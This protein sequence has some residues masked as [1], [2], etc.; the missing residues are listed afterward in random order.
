MPEIDDIPKDLRI[1]VRR[2]KIRLEA[3]MRQVELDHRLIFASG[4]MTAEKFFHLF[5]QPALAQLNDHS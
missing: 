4:A 5:L 1:E 2:G 3:N